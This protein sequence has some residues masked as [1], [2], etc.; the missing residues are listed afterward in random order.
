MGNKFAHRHLQVDDLKRFCRK[1]NLY[2]AILIVPNR[3]PEPDDFV[4][5]SYGSD[6]HKCQT[7]AGVADKIYSKFTSRELD[8]SNE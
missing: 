1:H 6:R 7:L 3:I 4:V 5:V 8:F 2:G